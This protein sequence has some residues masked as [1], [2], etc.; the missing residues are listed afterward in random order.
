MCRDENTS[1]SQLIEN[2]K[3]NIRIP[4]VL[5]CQKKSLSFHYLTFSLSP[6]PPF[7]FTSAYPLQ[8]GK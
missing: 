6:P 2:S 3:I 5:Y 1:T 7:F 4:F 8:H